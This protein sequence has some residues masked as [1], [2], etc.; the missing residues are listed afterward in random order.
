MH[1]FMVTIVEV[2]KFL[3]VKIKG[4]TEKYKENCSKHKQ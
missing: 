1:S 4:E 3:V 2:G